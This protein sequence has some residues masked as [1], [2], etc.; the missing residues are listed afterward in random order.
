VDFALWGREG[1]WFWSLSD[2]RGTGGMIGV[3]TNEAQA[4]REA[5][6]SIDEILTSADGDPRAR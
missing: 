2:P 5:R 6:S 3:S 1:A 4:V